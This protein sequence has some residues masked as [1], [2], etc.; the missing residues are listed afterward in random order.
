MELQQLVDEVGELAQR[1]RLGAINL[2]VAAAKVKLSNPAFRAA[3][4][5]I[6]QLVTR[7][8]EVASRVDRLSRQLAGHP[9]EEG[10]VDPGPESLGHLETCV[11]DVEE[12]SGLIVAE[13]RRLS[14]LTGPTTERSSTPRS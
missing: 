14:E 5:R 10:F 4:D 13:V 9:Q 1:T 12:L 7:A 11:S 3:N 6:V 8:T 2:A